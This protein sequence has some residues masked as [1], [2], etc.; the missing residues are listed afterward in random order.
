MN[1]SQGVLFSD[2]SFSCNDITPKE[3][4]GRIDSR[5]LLRDL[6]KAYYSARKNKRRTFSQMEFETHYEDHIIDLWEEIQQGVYTP[7]PSIAFVKK[8]PVIR[9]VFAPAFRDRVVHHYIFQKL[10]PIYEK[11]FI[12]DSYSCRK[13]KGTLYGI[14][15]VQGFLRSVHKKELHNSFILKLDIKNYFYS[16]D[17]EYLF[18]LLEKKIK[19]ETFLGVDKEILLFLVKQTIFNDPTKN[20]IKKGSSKEWSLLPRSKSLFHAPK[21]KGLAIGNLTSQLFSNIYLH[22]FDCFIRDELLVEYYGR[23][24]D[25]FVL[26]HPSQDFLKSCI[27][28]IQTRL[29][30]LGLSL[31]PKKIYLQHYKK[32]LPFLGAYITPFVCYAENRVKKNAYQCIHSIQ[33][34][35]QNNKDTYLY[36]ERKNIQSSLNSYLGTIAQYSSFSL[37]K[38]MLNTFPPEFWENFFIRNDYASIGMQKI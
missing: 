18:S 21:G 11:E 8:K 37:R 31:H 15:R 1:S 23:Y 2:D 5:N 22:S 10:S 12:P 6:F 33:K 27:P 36:S 4:S 34:K 17:R 35:M 3:Y 13:G 19:S 9:E 28:K 26:I 38:K 7:S 20:V 25:D 29:S 24:V 14:K 30:S 16:L 32:G